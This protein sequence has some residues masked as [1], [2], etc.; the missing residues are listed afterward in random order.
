MYSPMR[1]GDDKEWY[2]EW[3]LKGIGHSVV[4]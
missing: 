3:D 4:K 1:C 2:V